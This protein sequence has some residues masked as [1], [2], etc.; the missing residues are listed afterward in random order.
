[1]TEVVGQSLL[2]AVY[3]ARLVEEMQ[4]NPFA[5][6][7]AWLLTEYPQIADM[8]QAQLEF[9]EISETAE[10]LV[11]GPGTRPERL[12]SKPGQSLYGGVVEVATRLT[13]KYTGPEKP[14][15]YLHTLALQYATDLPDVGLFANDLVRDTFTEY[16]MFRRMKAA[17]DELA[18]QIET[19]VRRDPLEGYKLLK[20]IAGT[21]PRPT[22]RGFDWPP[23]NMLLCMLTMAGSKLAD[24]VG[25]MH[26]RREFDGFIAADIVAFL[27]DDTHQRP[28]GLLK[29]NELLHYTITYDFDEAEAVVHERFIGNLL[30]WP[31]EQRIAFESVKGQ[32]I[33]GY[34]AAMKWVR[35]S[36]GVADYLKYG[37]PS[38]D[39]L[40]DFT[41]AL[42]KYVESRM[43]PEPGDE[44]FTNVTRGKQRAIIERHKHP[45]KLQQGGA[46]AVAATEASN[47]VEESAAKPWELARLQ[48]TENNTR[49]MR[50]SDEDPVAALKKEYL[51]GRD[52]KDSRM[53]TFITAALDR[54]SKLD[55]SKTP[56]PGYKKLT[57]AK[58]KLDN[59]KLAP[60]FEYIP[61]IDPTISVSAEGANK[62]RIL[63]V[64]LGSHTLGVLKIIEE[65]GVSDYLRNSGITHI[66]HS[67]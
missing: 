62:I 64:N 38:P 16:R 26:D 10:P 36:D 30:D 43:Q 23:R 25:A 20:M 6:D 19:Q 1:M 34:R 24:E 55:L 50:V 61:G 60:I 42:G 33:A 39:L 12:R 9:E 15:A 8:R 5:V 31:K 46:L 22:S 17:S 65:G 49:F 59:G 4:H 3:R 63:V 29:I 35:S 52:D 28:N 32:L 57:G 54:L 66:A 47:T 7:D 27:S 48:P 58:I 44:G 37:E 67:K 14:E 11:V 53:D 21:I 45:K 41:T 2:A 56:V 40:R 51:A 18:P 13:A